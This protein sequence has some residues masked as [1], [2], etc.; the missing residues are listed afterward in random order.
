MCV[1][2]VTALHNWRLNTNLTAE[3]SSDLTVSGWNVML[4]IAHRYQL[5][6][7]S[8]L[9]LIYNRNNFRFRHTDRQ[10]TQASVRAFADGLFGSRS[11]ERV[12]FDDVPGRDIL[13]RV[14]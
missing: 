2:D 5:A 8:L 1:P 4:G 12:V 3:F 6:F 11:F 9:P 14:S 13:L 7:P 10:R